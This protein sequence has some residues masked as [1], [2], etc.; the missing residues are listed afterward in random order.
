MLEFLRVFTTFDDLVDA[1]QTL[2]E[3]EAQTR[4]QDLLALGPYDSREF[5]QRAGDSNQ[6]TAATYDALGL[7]EYHALEAFVRHP[8]ARSAHAASQVTREP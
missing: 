6:A 1:T 8:V 4:K 5:W 2:G 3:R 7:P